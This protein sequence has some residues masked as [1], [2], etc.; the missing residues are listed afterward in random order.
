MRNK[1]IILS[2]CLLFASAI[3]GS[4]TPLNLS[5]PK[6]ALKAYLRIQRKGGTLKQLR[7]VVSKENFTIFS[8]LEAATEGKID[9]TQELPPEDKY[10][11]LTIVK[12]NSTEGRAIFQLRVKYKES[13]LQ[14]EQKEM[15]E[16]GMDDI[17]SD[18]KTG[19][20]AISDASPGEESDYPCHIKGEGHV[21]FLFLKQNGAWR[22]H[23]SYASNQPSDF[24]PLLKAKDLSGGFTV[25][26]R[27]E[28]SPAL[29]KSVP[30]QPLA[31]RH[32][33][34]DW[35]GLFAYH[36]SFFSDD[37]HYGVDVLE[38]KE[39]EKFKR[40]QQP[41][42]MVKIPKKPGQYQLS[43]TFNV[44][45]FEPPGNNKTATDGILKV[46]HE[47]G[48]YKVHLIAHFDKDNDVRGYFTFTPPEGE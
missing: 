28:P 26:A 46:T 27:T 20:E 34:K 29:P 12:K 43:P 3:A 9:L 16:M 25:T 37:D 35:K 22:F 18:Q 21:S 40:F 24:S 44:T 42:L 6:E 8:A 14:Q 10:A 1:L 31:G 13:W 19:G 30:D 36:S 15:K 48:T 11:K 33:G 2:G 17:P 7:D 4:A 32:S 39:P 23:K 38:K 5:S 41:E 47:G 45:F